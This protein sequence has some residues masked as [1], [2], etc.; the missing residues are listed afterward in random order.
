MKQ[1]SSNKKFHCYF[2]GCFFWSS[3]NYMAGKIH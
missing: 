2:T 1:Q 3:R